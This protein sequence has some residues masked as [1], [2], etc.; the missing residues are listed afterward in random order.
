MTAKLTTGS[1]RTA[2]VVEDEP[3][4]RSLL[5]LH[6]TSAGFQV[7]ECGD[8]SAAVR[9]LRDEVFDLIVLDVMLPGLDG[10]SICRAV[11]SGGPN[12]ES[13]ILMVTAR[14]AESDKVIGL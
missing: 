4:I 11:R 6:L 7:E 2:F 1:A 5:R 3:P 10:V 13:P 14:D 8:G 9:R 12:V